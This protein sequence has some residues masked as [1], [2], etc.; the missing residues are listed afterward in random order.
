LRRMGTGAETLATILL[1]VSAIGAATAIGLELQAWGAAG[2]KPDATSQGAAVFAL[3]GWSA[4]FAAIGALM[5]L[6]ILLRRVFGRLSADRPSTVDLIGLFLAY[7]AGQAAMVL[8]L[9]RL[10][11]GNGS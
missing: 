7:T 11:P 3:L 8:L 10:F 6:Y 4:T 2:L 1:V 5:G 9:I